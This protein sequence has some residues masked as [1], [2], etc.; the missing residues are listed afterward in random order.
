MTPLRVAAI[1][2]TL[3][4]A[5]C[6]GNEIIT[7]TGQAALDA[8]TAKGMSPAQA[9]IMAQRAAT[10]VAQRDLIER[11]AGSFLSSHTEIRNFVAESDRII[12]QTGGLIK[13]AKVVHVELAPDQSAYMVV[14]QA[15][16]KDLR[17][18]LGSGPQPNIAV[19]RS[20]AWPDEFGGVS[21]AMNEPLRVDPRLETVTAKGVGIIPDGPDPLVA[22]LQARRSAKIDALRN[23]A[24]KVKG[25]RLNSTTTVRDFV[26]ERDEISTKIDAVIRGAAIVTERENA[27]G[28]IE[29][30]IA[31]R[32]PQIR[33]ALGVE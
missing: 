32:L 28:T 26:A 13:G 5:G 23:L 6:A 19:Q 17:Q 16:E 33:N 18:T 4:L 2:A 24:E 8:Y 21:T 15:M 14:I 1:F 29:V 10:L 31:V 9:A 11:Y 30:E 7:G 3:S 12:S 25:I 27:D 20:I 22:R